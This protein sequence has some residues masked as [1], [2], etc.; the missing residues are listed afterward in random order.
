M[1]TVGFIG[2]G[3]MGAGM[4]LRLVDAGHTVRVWNRSA[5]PLEPLVAAG[6]VAVDSPSDA[7]NAGV[8]FSM[9]SNDA[10]TDAVFTDAVLAAAPGSVH[11]NM[12]TVS[13]EKARELSAR[14]EAHG[15]RYV[16]A[17]VLG[18]PNLAATGQLNIVSAGPSDA[19]DRA[20]EFFPAL[21]KRVWRVGAAPE[22]A[23]LVKIG[24]NYNLIH[25]LQTL[26]ESLNLIERGGVDGS[27]FVEILTDAAYTGAA[28]V[29]YGA[30]IA[31]RSYTP[32][33][34]SV[35]LGLKDLSLA[36]AAAAE[37]GA[38]L[39]TAPVIQEIFEEALAD[40]ELSTLDWSAVAEITRRR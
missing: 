20:D 14:H 38:A 23:N 31:G 33:A 35:A 4:A 8:A 2:L 1:S 11:V 13:L 37:T 16:A 15:V 21:G 24:V 12:A 29:G 7:L 5:A 17:P 19:L 18:R 36:R 39:P 10:A 25:T 3:T 9:L 34:F 28:Y 30:L 27:T 22:K 40:E 26:A 32:P 6:A